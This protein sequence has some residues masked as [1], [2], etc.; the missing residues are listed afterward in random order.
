VPRSFI[1]ATKRG[2]TADAHARSGA[3]SNRKGGANA[4]ARCGAPGNSCR[5]ASCN[6]SYNASY[7]ASYIA[8]CNASRHHNPTGSSCAGCTRGA[9]A[10]NHHR[11]H[12]PVARS[13]SAR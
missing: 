11:Y 13:D 8:S 1:D 10:P 3:A 6:A 4:S 2:R 12:C 7:I 5:S 9:R